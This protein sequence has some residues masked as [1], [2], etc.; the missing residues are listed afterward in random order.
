MDK[1][2]VDLVPESEVRE[3]VEEQKAGEPDEK[4]RA[5]AL[6]VLRHLHK[7]GRLTGVDLGKLKEKGIGL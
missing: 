3:F 4:M 6:Q 2:L 7:S 1:P 5:L